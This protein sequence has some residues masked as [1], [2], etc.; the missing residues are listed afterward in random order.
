MGKTPLFRRLNR[1]LALARAANATGL[2]AAALVELESTLRAARSRTGPSRR[3]LLR[4]AA[5]VGAGTVVGCRRIAPPKKASE[6]AV[7]GAGIA[8]LSCAYR[9]MQAGVPVR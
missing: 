9:L 4:T 2:D 3:D 5:I 1:A 8:G 6:V 7:V